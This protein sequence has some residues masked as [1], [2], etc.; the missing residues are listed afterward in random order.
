MYKTHY[1]PLALN[2]LKDIVRYIAHTLESPQAA[3]NFISKIDKEVVK[4]AE[5]PFRC[6]LY[7]SSEKLKYDYRVLHI[8]N[9]SL[10]YAVENEKI[11]IHRVI[12]SRRDTVRILKAQEIN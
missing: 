1:L 4:I 12:Y 7:T 5:N 6:R 11:E 8:N 9:Y 3:E 10:F 2:D